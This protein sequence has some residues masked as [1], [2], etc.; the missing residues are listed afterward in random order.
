LLEHAIDVRHVGRDYPSGVERVAALH[1][2]DLIVDGGESVAITGISGSGKTTLLNLI[3]GLDQPTSGEIHVL[4]QNLGELGEGA[5]TAFRAKS[6]GL[7]FQDPH[8]LP[9]LSAV[10]NV[11][12]ARLPWGKR[13]ELMK[14][15]KKLLEL[16]A[17]GDRLHHPPSRLSGGE[18][19]RVGLARAL[20]GQP[21]ILLADEPTGNLDAKTTEGLIEL[22]S[23]LREEM[24]ITLVIA[25]HDPAVAAM[26]QRIVRLRGGTLE[27]DHTVPAPRSIDTS[28]P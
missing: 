26:A 4:G 24:G 6:I 13:S 9:G 10:E 3:A 23:E 17:L 2:V 7:V 27:S 8:L 11:A 28:H 16:L 22:L 14:E 12:L 25:T 1:D 19:Q 18:R 5:L 15:A 20:L 21:R